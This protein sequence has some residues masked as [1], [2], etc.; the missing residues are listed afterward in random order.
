[1]LVDDSAPGQRVL[2]TDPLYD[3]SADVSVLRV[4]RDFGEQSRAG[5]LY[6][7]RQFGNAFSKVTAG[8]TFIKLTDNWFT[9]LLTVNTETRLQNGTVSNGRQTNWRVNRNGRNFLA[10][11]HWTQQSD[12][13]AVPLGIL[14]R[15]YVPGAEG[16]HGFMEYR[17]WPKSSWINRIG[18]RLFFANQDDLTGQ[19]IYNEFSP[20]MQVLWSGNSQFNIGVNSIQ[21]RLR[22]RDF[23]GLLATR[24]YS[25]RRWFAS[26]TSDSLSKLG[27]DLKIDSGTVI[28]L[29]PAVGLQPELADRKQIEAGLRWRPMDRLRVDTTY[30][31]T[32]LDDRNG[33]GRIFDDE[34]LRARFNFQF[35]KEMSLRFIAQLEDTDPTALSSLVRRKNLNLDV[36]FRYVLNPYSAL[37]VG[38]NNNESNLQLVDTPQ[39][40]QVVRTEDLARDGEQMF[41]KFSYLLQP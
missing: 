19:R 28:N 11:Y 20:Q 33:S 36:L 30:L 22:P 6:T 16:L 13:F 24:D 18:P 3:E 7:D 12:R 26:L 35:T 40:T 10:H 1:M 38:F 4:F 32:Q 34:I 27:Y 23:P 21:E 37:Y 8:D 2:P 14:G 39:G 25:Q 5:V 9:E 15:N 29:V 31:S 17:F 41:V